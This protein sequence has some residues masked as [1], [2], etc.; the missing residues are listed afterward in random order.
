MV[1][2]H[3]CNFIAGFVVGMQY[4]HVE[5]DDYLIV[6]LGFFEIIFIW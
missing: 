4:E 1:E 3:A 6:S 5:G 2:L